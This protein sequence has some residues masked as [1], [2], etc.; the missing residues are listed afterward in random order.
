MSRPITIYKEHWDVMRLDVEARFPVE[1]CGLVAGKQGCSEWVRPI[2]NISRSPTRFRLD[3]HQQLEAMLLI[4]EQGLEMMAIFH[5]HPH[6]P[7]IPSDQD[8]EESAY[9]ETV[10]L[11]W[12]PVGG[13]W[14]C[15]GY[16]INAGKFGEV[17]LNIFE[18]K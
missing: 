16:F 8:V 2:T 7:A 6:G 13:T 4:E 5:S 15:R 1:A 18:N 11:I 9:P 10:N 17:S 3:P 12:Y 14:D